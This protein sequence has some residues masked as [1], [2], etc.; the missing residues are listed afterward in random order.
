MAIAIAPFTLGPLGI[1]GLFNE[2]LY[3]S[4]GTAPYTFAVTAGALPTG[5]GLDTAGIVFGTPTTAGSYTFTATATD[6]VPNTGS[7][8]YTIVVSAVTISPSAL[9]TATK[10]S[11][12]SVTLKGQ[13]GS[14][15]YTFS[16]IA[17]ALPAGFTFDTV[18]G[19]ISGTPTESGSSS[20]LI[21]ARDSRGAIG[22]QSYALTVKPAVF[23]YI[24]MRSAQTPVL[25]TVAADQ[26]EHNRRVANA[27]ESLA[28][29]RHKVGDVKP[30]PAL[31]SIPDHLLCDGSEVSRA[32][33]PQLFAEIGTTWGAGDGSTTFN[34]P[35][36]IGAALPVALTAP[37]QVISS[38]G[39]VS[40]G[41]PVTAPTSPGEAGGTTGGN[42]GTGGKFV[43]DK[44][45]FL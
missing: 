27:L 17:G 44:A 24:C 9:G 34:I 42:I 26:R 43:L 15:P 11:A 36:L 32:A 35:D 22:D 30:R 28:K 14:A 7:R 1:G 29:S 37:A 39:T 10:D 31:Q 6:A 18:T 4:G 41:E 38:G 2:H 21:R 8:D 25:P 16:L 5:L 13:G 33:F 12:Y 19:V 3:A 45:S 20:F 40:A 23:W